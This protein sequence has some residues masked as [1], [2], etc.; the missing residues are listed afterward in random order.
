MSGHFQLVF[1]VASDLLSRNFSYHY[2]VDLFCLDKDMFFLFSINIENWAI[3][4]HKSCKLSLPYFYTGSSSL[5]A[6]SRSSLSLLSR[7]Q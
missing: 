3:I 4:L 6:S 2:H 7:I 1:V 5:N